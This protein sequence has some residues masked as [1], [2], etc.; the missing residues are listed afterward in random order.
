MSLG[1]QHPISILRLEF[2][3]DPVQVPG[4]MRHLVITASYRFKKSSAISYKEGKYK[5]GW[6]YRP[7][8]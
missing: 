2:L 6:G 7:S 3:E 8:I 4:G 5:E 1:A